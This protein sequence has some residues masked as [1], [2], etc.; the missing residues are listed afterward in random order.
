MWIPQ[1]N[2]FPQLAVASLSLLTELGYTEGSVGYKNLTLWLP[3]G[4]SAVEMWFGNNK[5]NSFFK[6]QTVLWDCLWNAD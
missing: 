3:V 2:L 4:L 5:W 1:H 6:N